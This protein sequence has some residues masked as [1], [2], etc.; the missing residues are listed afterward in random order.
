MKGGIQNSPAVTQ[1]GIVIA[2]S[3]EGVMAAYDFVS[4]VLQWN[5][6]SLGAYIISSPTLSTDASQNYTYVTVQGRGQEQSLLYSLMTRTGEIVFRR[7]LYVA[8]IKPGSAYSSP[9]MFNDS[10]A[11]LVAVGDTFFAIQALNQTH[12]GNNSCCKRY[13]GEIIWERTFPGQKLLSS[14]V[15]RDNLAYYTTANRKEV[16]AVHSDSGTECWAQSL[17]VY[18]SSTP[19][20]DPEFPIMY[21]TSSAGVY[22]ID[23]GGGCVSTSR[24]LWSYAAP[25]GIS[26]VALG[27]EGRNLYF[28][29]MDD[30]VI[31]LRARDAAVG[32][33]ASV[34]INWSY[35]VNGALRLSSPVVDEQEIVYVTTEG[36]VVYAFNG[37]F[38][39]PV[40]G[41]TADEPVGDTRLLL[42]SYETDTNVPIYASP[43]LGPNG[44]VIIASTSGQLL[45]ITEDSFSPGPSILKPALDDGISD[46]VLAAVIISSILLCCVISLGI[47]F[48]VYEKDD[49]QSSTALGFEGPPSR[50]TEGGA[51]EQVQA[52]EGRGGDMGDADDNRDEES[53]YNIS[54]QTYLSQQRRQQSPLF[55]QEL[56]GA[57]QLLRGRSHINHMR[58]TSS[59]A[60]T[61]GGEG[62]T[63]VGA[64]QQQQ[65]GGGKEDSS[66]EESASE[67]SYCDESTTACSDITTPTLQR[68]QHQFVAAVTQP[69]LLP[70]MQSPAS[71]QQSSTRTP[72]SREHSQLQPRPSQPQQHALNLHPHDAA[73]ADDGESKAG[74]RSVAESDDEY[75]LNLWYG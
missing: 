23:I 72:I 73:E 2:G 55:Q 62:D 5:S 50:P 19:V 60:G 44:S 14:A 24:V 28:G 71:S 16:V 1:E 65:T 59:I 51:A 35:G 18:T 25:M 15:V 4:G 34:S 31:S 32:I 39:Q 56:S 70:S 54:Y 67:V 27:N 20:L 29:T 30:Q 74:M 36:G 57:D 26:S 61:Y 40:L 17:D 7:N 63:F 9:V 42:W 64:S 21:I 37:S 3:M 58:V 43:A 33:N 22:A 66:Y 10:S 13:A 48:C 53:S 46:G 12:D 6:S 75:R 11:L 38:E 45:V 52:Q 8:N 49:D 69:P 47:W 41:T 68:T